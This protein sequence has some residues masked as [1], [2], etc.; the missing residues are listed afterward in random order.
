MTNGL[1]KERI[2]LMKEDLLNKLPYNMKWVDGYE[3]LYAVSSEGLVYSFN[4]YNGKQMALSKNTHGYYE[5]NLCKD[6]VRTKHRIH[7]LVAQAF[8]PNPYGLPIVNHIDGDKTNNEVS[9]LEWASARD[10][11]VHSYKTML[12]PKQKAVEQLE[13]TTGSV[14]GRYISTMEAERVTGIAHNSISKVC[15]GKRRSAGGFGW[16]YAS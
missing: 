4:K 5:L 14:V 11:I 10:N 3:G 2:V 9:N 8:A 15:L 13:I 1:R 12:D 7:R 16:K 6:E